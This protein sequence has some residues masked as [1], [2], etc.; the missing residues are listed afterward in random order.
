MDG[1]PIYDFLKSNNLTTKDESSF[2]AEYANPAKAKELHSFLSSNNLTTKGFDDFYGTYLKKKGTASLPKPAVPA[3]LSYGYGADLKQASENASRGAS[4][5]PLNGGL[6]EERLQKAA[7]DFKKAD[8]LKAA[9][10]AAPAMEDADPAGTMQKDIFAQSKTIRDQRQSLTDRYLRSDSQPVTLPQAVQEDRTGALVDLNN[11]NRE[12]TQKHQALMDVVNNGA[13]IPTAKANE[14][15]NKWIKQG[16]PD[17]G[18]AWTYGREQLKTM[19][20]K[21]ELGEP[22]LTSLSVLNRFD[23][24]RKVL[25]SKT[26]KT[27]EDWA[28]NWAKAAGKTDAKDTDFE[29]KHGGLSGAHMGA[30]NW[31]FANQPAVKEWAA[32]SPE[33]QAQYQKFVGNLPFN[34][35][36]F[37]KTLLAQTITDQREGQGLNSRWVNTVWDKKDGKDKNDFV[38]DGLLKEGKID[39]RLYDFYQKNKADV[40]DK[41]KTPGLLETFAGSVKHTGEDILNLPLDITKDATFHAFDDTEAAAKK[42][43]A[44]KYTNVNLNVKDWW[45]E[46]SQAMGQ[47]A[48]FML[49]VSTL[50]KGL[51]AMKV[52]PKIANV[53]A[54]VA[55]T[56]HGARKSALQMFPDEPWKQAA[57]TWTVT[58]LNGALGAVTSGK[59]KAIEGLSGLKGDI[60]TLAKEAVGKISGEEIN[61]AAKADL[62]SGFVKLVDKLKTGA[63][64]TLKH[65][66]ETS[67][68]MGGLTL[69][70]DLADHLY[71]G[72]KVTWMDAANDFAQTVKTMFIGNAP[73]AALAAKAGMER[74]VTASGL[75]EMTKDPVKYERLI[76]ASGE[77]DPALSATVDERLQNFETARRIKQEM[78]ADED[79]NGLD[80]SKKAQYLLQSLSQKVL[81]AKLKTTTDNFLKERIK[82][83]LEDSRA[84]QEKI[85]L[86]HTELRPQDYG[87]MPER[88]QELGVTKSEKVFAP[89]ASQETEPA[90]QEPTSK[91]HE[92]ADPLR[93][94]PAAEELQPA[95]TPNPV[96]RSDQLTEPGAKRTAGET[97]TTRNGLYTVSYENG[98]RV[99]RDGTGNAPSE[100][101]QK[102]YLKEHALTLNYGEGKTVA[103]KMESGEV[104]QPQFSHPSEAVKFTAEHS[105][106]PAEVAETY[107]A[108][109]KENA[110]LSSKEEAIA[111]YGI[112]KVKESSY[113]EFGDGNNIT[114]GKARTY[115]KKDGRSLDVVAK[116]I[117]DH[118]G[119][120]IEPSDL[121]DFM[122]RFQKGEGDALRLRETEGHAALKTRFEDLTGV[123]LTESMAIEAAKQKYSPDEIAAAEK[124]LGEELQTEPLPE[125]DL[126]RW[127]QETAEMDGTENEPTFTD[128]PTSDE[129]RTNF[130]EPDTEQPQ[131]ENP[132]PGTDGGAAEDL[133]HEQ[134]G[135]DAAATPSESERAGVEGS[136]EITG[137]KNATTLAEREA[138]GLKEV[139]VTARRSFGEAFDKGKALVDNSQ[140]DPRQFATDL[141]DKPRPLSAEE[142]AAL[143]YDRMRLY[144]EHRQVMQGIDAATENGDEQT[145]SGLRTRMAYLEE[146]INTNDEAS[147]RAGYEQGL[148]LAARKMMIKEDY[149]LAH[150][151]QRMKAASGGKE[152]PPEVRAK[153][154]LYEKQLDEAYKKL[155][156]HEEKIKAME[157]EGAVKETVREV[158]FERRKA[159]RS[160]TR[161]QLK[162]ERVDLLSQLKKLATD[163]E[164]KMKDQGIQ[165][166]GFGGPTLTVEMLPVI[167]K[168]VRNLVQEGVVS[169]S[170]LIDD[171]H[172]QV[173]EHVPGV[174][175]RELQDAI[176]GYG[177]VKKL[178]QEAIDIE[179]RDIKGQLRE[180]SKLDDLETGQHPKRSG[181]QRDIPSDELRGLRKKVYQ[182]M[183][184]AGV[185]I[186]SKTPEEA[187]RTALDAVKAR[188]RNRIADLDN[189]LKT[190]EKTP[191]KT[192]VAYDKDAT[193]LKAEADRLKAALVE[194][195]G[196]PELSPEQR[197]KIATGAVEKSIEEYERRIKEFDLTPSKKENKTPETPELKALRGKRQLL[198]NELDVMRNEANP[199]KSP[200][201]QSLQAFKTRL[202]NRKA[203]LEKKLADKDFTTKPKRKLTVD[204]E[205]LTLQAEVQK[206]KE[207]FD[208]EK[209]KFEQ[210]ARTPYEKTLDVLAKWRREALLTGVT[211]LGKLGV[212]ASARI[213]SSPVEEIVGGLY[214]KIPG[215]SHIAAAAPREGG[216]SV[217]AEAEAISKAFS[218][219]T[220]NQA[221]D[222]IKSGKSREDR[223]FGKKK[224]LP[225]EAFEFFGRV[226]GAIKYIAKKAEFY[227]ALEKRSE[228]AI[229]KGF[230]VKDPLV[231]ATV[232]SQAYMDANRSIFMN[233]NI[234]N[235]VYRQLLGSL[236]TKGN[237]GKTAAAIGRMLM[238]IVKVPT[239]FVLETT[240]YTLGLPKAAASIGY[241]FVKGIHNLEPAHADYIMRMLKK[242]SVGAALFAVGYLNPQAIGGYYTGKRKKDDLEA[243]ELDVFGMH[244]PHWA[245]HIPLIEVMQFGATTRRVQDAYHQKHPGESGLGEGYFTAG[246]GLLGEVPFV[247]QPKRL[248]KAAA[249]TDNA[250]GFAGEFAK[251]FIVPTGVQEAANLIDQQKDAKGQ[252]VKRSPVSFLDHISAGIPFLRSTVPTKEEA[253]KMKKKG[254]GGGLGGLLGG[255]LNG[256]LK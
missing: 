74:K 56:E 92:N 227:R 138:R 75:W 228:Y 113:R 133:P 190:G 97:Y 108:T 103:Q 40:D 247:D 23:A 234:A 67:L 200:E 184:E 213:V 215:L 217:K 128:Q 8:A 109:P 70:Q 156:A 218:L 233:D 226:H 143:I 57:Y 223:L 65:N 87:E 206:V 173:V 48:G 50:T 80:E 220:W 150:Q 199:A 146:A 30:V 224:D 38:M 16:N 26:G 160:K 13:D 167:G 85:V 245:Q 20:P 127:M 177:N 203:D 54:M 107:L 157:A 9:Q 72:R 162:N 192:G 55:A 98:K 120:E 1:N 59:E 169:A 43:V 235:D 171:L 27:F 100:R 252:K 17:A 161:E 76:K 69:A 181:M 193:D 212:A 202:I 151:L 64:A 46:V 243:N 111:N 131:T 154:E 185:S 6:S 172:K 159:V 240:H 116:E 211:T 139:E 229:K 208:L 196:K 122:D 135:Q 112:G 7:A 174:T 44:E 214:S 144:Q 5:S 251:G 189:Q 188:L 222:I 125:D 180:L 249:S 130:G 2:L 62:T 12:L 207:K 119:M 83:Q 178:S 142:S 93:Q 134:R 14:Q 183:K 121:V 194:I 155:E 63:D 60:S 102:T 79:V 164:Q 248:I 81:E 45:G 15:L 132:L 209:Y 106:N 51:T 152:V 170:Q 182:K 256:N 117:S 114:N 95:A 205:G 35:P 145:A 101:T 232:S 126:L 71:G 115:F 137:I 237:A 53:A 66:I 250:K 191:K 165:K 123:P 149:S 242:G 24:N 99:V 90:V 187:Q 255:S 163:H 216:F 110:G 104:A 39:Q 204:M 176:S 197:V 21:N 36:D 186:S 89:E 77:L 175:K 91:P 94:E 140:L 219:D 19:L 31:Q 236:A 49:P 32:Q 221:V 58:A 124:A 11:K 37:G 225:T 73:F 68:Q 41:I 61:T 158:Q 78:L 147:R 88:M 25:T 253:K 231:L 96:E 148:G 136:G 118:T 198:K 238:P 129:Q 47:T 34:Y 168:L 201:E 3:G 153:L 241:A 82:K 10:A 141:A 210:A 246:T 166:S 4:S 29:E 33:H 179:I 22:T 18:D 28:L 195:E 52:A 105:E 42:A 86:R 84:E 230:D 239:N 254:G 244:V